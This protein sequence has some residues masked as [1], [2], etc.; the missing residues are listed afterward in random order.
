MHLCTYP[1]SDFAT[2]SHVLDALS[3]CAPFNAHHVVGADVGS[4]VGT[5]VGKAVGV[6]VGEPVG[7]TVGMPVGAIVGALVGMTVGTDV[8]AHDVQLHNVAP[9]T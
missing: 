9:L 6:L 1:P 8:G 3:H 4:A 7:S 2:S 5:K